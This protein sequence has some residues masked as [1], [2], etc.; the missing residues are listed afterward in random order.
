MAARKIGHQL[1]QHLEADEEAV[2]RILVEVVGA[3]EELIEQRVLALDVADE[4]SLGELALVLEMIE[5]SALGDADGGDQ[6]FDRSGGESFV[7]DGSLGRVENALARI[8]ALPLL[9]VL[10]GLAPL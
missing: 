2:Q 1:R 7:E 3:G 8:S 5:E 4:Q 9:R 10:H 6:L